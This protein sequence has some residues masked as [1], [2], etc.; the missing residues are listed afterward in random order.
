M[1]AKI[2]TQIQIGLTD[3]TREK[4]YKLNVC[5]CLFI[6]P[7][8]SH[9]NNTRDTQV[10]L[11]FNNNIMND[12]CKQDH[13]VEPCSRATRALLQIFRLFSTFQKIP[14]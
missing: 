7:S 1:E 6:I 8:D 13:P 2:K 3:V 5:V 10:H 12:N 11:Q 14:T 9:S 4:R